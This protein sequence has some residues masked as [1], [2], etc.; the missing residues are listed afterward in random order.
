MSWYTID[1]GG[2]MSF[3]GRY[4]LA[5]TIGQPD[6]D[7]CKGGKYELL[8][9]FWPGSPIEEECLPSCH[10]DYDQ[11]V[12]VGMPAC[13]CYERQCH[14]DADGAQGGGAEM[15]YYYVGPADF[16]VLVDGWLVKEPPHGPGIA[17]VPGGICADFGHDVEGDTDTG[18]YRIGLSDLNIWVASYL[19][20][21]PPHGPG[22]D[23]DCLDCP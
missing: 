16:N 14:G 13:W 20:K 23:P 5:A 7:W 18:L 11:W 15:G 8:G 12:A 2:G 22:I 9:G 19:V 10:D 1:G 3:G 4:L 17:S 21:E 6:A